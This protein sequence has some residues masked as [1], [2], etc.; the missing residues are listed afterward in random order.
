MVTFDGSAGTYYAMVPGV[1]VVEVEVVVD[2]CGVYRAGT[3]VL[4]ATDCG[5]T[6][7]PGTTTAAP[8]TTAGP[9]VTTTTETPSG[10]TSGDGGAVDTTG[11]AVSA[12]V[13]VGTRMMGCSPCGGLGLQGGFPMAVS[14]L[15]FTF[16]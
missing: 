6:L 5:L 14:S 9:S 15:K 12:G 2:A 16:F 10:V 4:N 3:T 1:R 11:A 8:S 13:V 7:P